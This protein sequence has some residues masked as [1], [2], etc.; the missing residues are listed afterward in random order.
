MATRC[1]SCGGRYERVQRDG[2]IYFHACP[3]RI[4]GPD[5]TTVE[6]VYKRD[7]NLRG[8]TG[9]DRREPKREGAGA[10]EG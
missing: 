3:P 1:K 8:G 10:E 5:E 7:E 2:S 6:R 9:E 4:V